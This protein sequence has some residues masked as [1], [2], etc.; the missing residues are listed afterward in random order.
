[1]FLPAAC[2]CM[3]GF[4]RFCTLPAACMLFSF[5]CVG[6]LSSLPFCYACLPPPFWVA[7]WV[8]SLL[9]LTCHLPPGYVVHCILPFS[10]SGTTIDFHSGFSSAMLWVFSAPVRRYSKPQRF[11]FQVLLPYKVF[12]LR[13]PVSCSFAL[14]PHSLTITTYTACH[15]SVS[16]YVLFSLP[17]H[18][19]AVWVHACVSFWISA[20]Y[21]SAC[22][23]C[24]PLVTAVPPPFTGLGRCLVSFSL[25]LPTKF[26][27]ALHATRCSWFT[28]SCLAD[29][30]FFLVLDTTLL[31]LIP[32]LDLFYTH[33]SCSFSVHFLHYHRYRSTCV[34]PLSCSFYVLIKPY[35]VWSLH[36]LHVSFLHHLLH[37]LEVGTGTP[38]TLPFRFTCYTSYLTTA[39]RVTATG[40]PLTVH[41]L[42]EF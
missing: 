33:R 16:G 23:A 21:R 18:L 6:G 31:F 27:S 4:L 42:P 22:T 1:M 17:L 38:V 12:I 14:P 2:H 24:T 34:L 9:G 29:T 7:C 32:G 25:H 26:R 19:P 40:T 37:H 8:L 28:F 13:M 10:V 20:G 36:S 15:T 39:I 30:T 35:Y 41:V 5:L 3:G 11:A